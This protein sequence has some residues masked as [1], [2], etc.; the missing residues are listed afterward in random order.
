MLLSLRR[1][2]RAQLNSDD[3]DDVVM[4]KV[5]KRMEQ[6]ACNAQWWRCAGEQNGSSSASGWVGL[7][8]FRQGEG[9]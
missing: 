3:D 1:V 7:G 5:D 9:E 2:G 4:M 8:L 6:A